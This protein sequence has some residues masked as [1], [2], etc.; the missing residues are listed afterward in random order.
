M[1][2]VVLRDRSGWI[3]FR[4]PLRVLEAGRLEEVLPAI[5]EAEA[6]AAEGF[7]AAGFIAY[8]AAPAFDPALRVRADSA[9]P[10][11]GLGIFRAPRRIELP[12]P[13]PASGA[14]AWNPSVARAEYG[15]AFDRVKEELASG[16][17]YQVN[18]S[19]RLYAELAEDPWEVFLRMGGNGGRYSAYLDTGRWVVA[20]ASPELFLEVDGKRLLCMPMKGTAPRGL[21]PAEDRRR[22]DDL[23]ASEKDRA[24]N[25]MIVDM[26]RNDLGRVAEAGSVRVPDLFSVERYPNLWQ[27]TSTVRALSSAPVGEL[28]RA[29]FPCASITG[30]P[31]VAAMGIIAEL[32][33]SPRR[34]YTGSIA[35]IAPGRKATLSVAIRTLLFD[36]ETRR[37]EYGVGG[38][39]V[40]DSTAV[41]EY[42]EAMLKSR[43]LGYEPPAFSLLE[44]MLWRPGEGWAY[45]EEHLSRMLASAD[46]FGF[47]V[48]REAVAGFLSAS[49][50]AWA[51]PRRARILLSPAGKLSAESAPFSPPSSGSVMTAK[52]ALAP[53]D[54][55]E[56]LL[57]H[58][59]TRRPWY[60][61]ARLGLGGYDEILFY[62]AE[63]ELTEF[64][65]GNLVVERDGVLVTP[66]VECGL[67]PGTYRAR[68]LADGLAREGIL[69]AED[70]AGCAR[71]FF[72]NSV[73]GRR[74]I[75]VDAVAVPGPA[76]P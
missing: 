3:E 1:E 5:R 25:L 47:P 23:R 67:L 71:V 46:Y 4:D 49:A 70:L 76:V 27:M 14:I 59:T 64:S 30:A 60:D 66:P 38:A 39:V 29:A 15:A 45:L 21:W 37:A 9:F 28:C 68:L 41:S 65:Y 73:R 35:H 55:G 10:L 7:H 6:L 31:K 22:A 36:R 75:R 2:R 57:Y 74:E 56:S 24:E 51:E 40:W 12:P 16:N 52:L 43:A 72:A 58:K 63:G 61:D 19:F 11:C 69:R 32:E 18:L 53:I 8:E 13:S 20:S 26:V 48:E 42:D 34:V 50:E 44:T 17:S 62:N 54:R 33:T